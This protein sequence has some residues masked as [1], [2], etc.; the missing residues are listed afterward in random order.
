MPK[1]S[2]ITNCCNRLEYTTASVNS[3]CLNAA[4]ADYEHLVVNQN[5]SDGT[6]EWLDYVIGLPWFSRV[7]PIH[8]PE[9]LGYWKGYCAGF[10]ASQGDYI[11]CIDND[12]VVETPDFLNQLCE[13]LESSKFDIVAP[14]LR[15][16]YY[17]CPHRKIGGDIADPSSHIPYPTAFFMMKRTD[18][19]HNLSLCD[20]YVWHKKSMST[21]KVL[22]NQI[23]GLQKGQAMSLSKKKY[24]PHYVYSN[25]KGSC[26]MGNSPH[27]LPGFESEHYK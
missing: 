23:D 11:V 8:R 15:E 13:V 16:A 21:D 12:I 5:S 17:T 7:K 4:D 18:F 26:P 25:L 14:Q 9:N 22:A 2:V 19:I 3:I 1:Y 27:R 6:K 20:D 24:P 10:D